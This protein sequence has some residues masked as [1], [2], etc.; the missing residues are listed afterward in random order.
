MAIPVG[1]KVSGHKILYVF[2]KTFFI[3][4]IYACVVPE[5]IHTPTTEGIGNSRGVGGS[6]AQEILERRGG[7]GGGGGL[8]VN[9]HF[10]MVKFDAM[11]ICFK[12]VSYL[13]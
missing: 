11:Q 13:L 6:K 4:N 7:G 1:F 10:Q 8:L 2:F 5:N 12:I 3:L 9:L